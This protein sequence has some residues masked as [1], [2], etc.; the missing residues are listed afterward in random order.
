MFLQ[1]VLSYHLR[2]SRAVF[3]K[4]YE[5]LKSSRIAEESQS[6][7]SHSLSQLLYKAVRH[8]SVDSECIYG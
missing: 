1:N 3:C 7:E 8:S 6:A 5:P 2:T 4:G